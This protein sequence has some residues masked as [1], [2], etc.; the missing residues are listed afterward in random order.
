M[1]RPEWEKPQRHTHFGFPAIAF[2]RG[3]A[4]CSD[5][6]S[7]PAPLTLPW[8]DPQERWQKEVRGRPGPLGLSL[9]DVSYCGC[10]QNGSE[11]MVWR[12]SDSEGFSLPCSISSSGDP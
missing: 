8:A 4:G 5:L 7:S 11:D 1:C 6:P 9:L 10:L 2:L 12:K 3:K